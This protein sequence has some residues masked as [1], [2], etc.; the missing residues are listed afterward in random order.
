MFNPVTTC[1]A[2]QSFA[3][4][5]NGILSDIDSL[6][7]DLKNA[8]DPE[9]PGIINMIREDRKQLGEPRR[10]L[11]QC[12]LQNCHAAVP[13]KAA[14]FTGEA[15]LITDDADHRGPFQQSINATFS[16][17]ATLDSFF[18]SNFPMIKPMGNDTTID[19][20]GQQNASLDS[21]GDMA[22]DLTLHFDFHSIFAGNSD[23]VFH[24]TTGTASL[25]GPFQ[26]TGASIDAGGNV[27]LAGTTR[28]TSGF[29]D[30][31]HGQLVIAG[32]LSPWP[33]A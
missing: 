11:A 30:G 18:I 23:G 16:F 8:T 22:V 12:E 9:K 4:T 10:E 31:K 14:G 21:S 20:T 19:L 13:P 33:P 15:T 29:W 28:F 27:T 24:M 5:I 2:C 1:P 26:P 7:E 25:S 6:Q 32:Q 17:A 3:D